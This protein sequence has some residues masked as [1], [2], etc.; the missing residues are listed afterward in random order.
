M[1]ERR[2]LWAT[3]GG[4]GYDVVLAYASGANT[5]KLTGNAWDNAPLTTG[6]LSSTNGTDVASA[7]GTIDTSSPQTNIATACSAGRV[8]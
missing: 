8:K 3:C 1:A 2:P 4:N 6:N 7:G 5:A